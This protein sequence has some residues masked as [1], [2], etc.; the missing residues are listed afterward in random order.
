MDKNKLPKHVSIIMDGNG[1]WAKLRGKERVY[2]HFEGVE[3]VRACLETAVKLGIDYLSVYAFSEENWNRPQEEVMALMELIMKA[4]E[5]ELSNFMEHQVRFVVLGNRARLSD[6]VNAAIDHMSSLTSQNTGV[7]FVMFLS[8]SGKWDILQAAKKA[9]A[10]LTPEQFQ[11]M[12]LQDLDSYL[13]T[14]GIPDPDLL[15]RTSGELRISN[16]LLWQ[17]AYTE[18]YF[19]DTLWPD[20][21]E[22]Q[23][24]EA[25][26]AYATRDRRYGKVK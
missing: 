13:V 19:T 18:F 6:K 17:S 4:M 16:Y 5:N 20:F 22:P 21:R 3:S 9:A 25:L 24:M 10:T 23:F 8:Y 12:D 1:R 7:T 2:G 11:Q 26:E 15:I 14:A